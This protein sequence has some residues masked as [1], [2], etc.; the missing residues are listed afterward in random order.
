M[1]EVVD[2]FCNSPARAQLLKGL[3]AYR[4]HLHAGGFTSGT[5]WIDGSFVENVEVLRR[6][7]P[8]DI[9]VVTLFTRPLRY[10]LDASGWAR[11][12]E[13]HIFPTYFDTKIMKP[14]YKCDTYP[15]D[16]DAVPRAV[17]RNTIYWHGLFSD[18]REA[19]TKKGIVEIPLATDVME[20]S[21]IEQKI[22]GKF[23]V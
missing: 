18:M 10:Q 12:F 17:V 6:R 16:L 22:G 1:F 2:R 7:A 8:N 4:K 21:A 15:I 3:N 11:D 14:R 23:D 20:F 13:K 9:D 19:N 5:Q